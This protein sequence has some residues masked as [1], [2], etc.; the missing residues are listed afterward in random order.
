[1]GEEKK[2]L[3]RNQK[4]AIWAYGIVAGTAMVPTYVAMGVALS[5][6]KMPEVLACVDKSIDFA[7]DYG[8]KAV[9]SLL[10]VSGAIKGVDKVAT[11]VG[12]WMDA[13]RAVADQKGAQK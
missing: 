9:A 13:R 1:M 12:K 10:V 5:R 11:A 2:K 8:L 3:G 4:L 6:D 7:G